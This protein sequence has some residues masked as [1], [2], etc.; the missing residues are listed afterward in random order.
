MLAY[1]GNS[2]L[3]NVRINL[4]LK[5]D[6]TVKMLQSAIKKNV[7]IQLD[8]KRDVPEIFAD[9]AQI[10]QVVINLIINAAEAIGDRNG[11][12]K[13][14]LRKVYIQDGSSIKDFM[15]NA[16]LPGGYASV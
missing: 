15:G 3:Q 7:T 5:I 8:L 12:I 4:W 13:V 14:A 2:P 11:I 16:I 9:N 10:Q 1:A 6:E